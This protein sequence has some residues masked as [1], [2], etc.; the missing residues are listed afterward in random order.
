[1]TY[2]NTTRMFTTDTKK[3]T[4]QQPRNKLHMTFIQSVFNIL[5]VDVLGDIT[6][7]RPFA[8]HDL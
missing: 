3:K 6:T 7:I 2:A 8:V 1:M 4:R 5:I